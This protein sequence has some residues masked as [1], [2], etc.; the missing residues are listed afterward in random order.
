MS[1]ENTPVGTR[2][3][4][5]R[6]RTTSRGPSRSLAGKA[7]AIEPRI[8]ESPWADHEYVRGYA[9][10]VLPFSSGHLLALRAWPQSSFGPYVSVW[11]R[12]PEG[13]WSMFVDGPSL[14]TT[15]PRYWG[16]VTEQ[17]AL[18][19]IDVTW[20]GPNTLHVD[21]DE[22][23]LVWTMSVSASPLLRK[24]NAVSAS[25]PLWTWKPK[26]LLW[27]R[28]WMARRLLHMGDLEFSFRTPSGHDT[29]IMPEEVY[30]ITKSEAILD[31]DSLGVPVGLDTNPTIGDVP[32]PTLPSFVIGQAHMRIT[33]ADEYRRT[34]ERVR[35]DGVE[36]RE[37]AFA[38]DAT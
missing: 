19:S 14:E 3:L 27:P 35:E 36:R 6:D 33:D 21:V 10:M 13:Q 34:R 26:P 12:P 4:V 20:T 15:C 24:A 8:E 22:P 1:P 37:D 31:G 5:G 2:R 9:V 23:R 18:A 25:L 32:L 7:D 38:R 17:A 29:V 28:E 16:P 30:F 11:H